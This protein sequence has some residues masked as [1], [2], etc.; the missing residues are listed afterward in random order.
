[1]SDSGNILQE[2]IAADLPAS[3]PRNR[4][5]QHK[6]PLTAMTCRVT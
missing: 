4:S 3:V 1:M 5:R 6:P 2:F